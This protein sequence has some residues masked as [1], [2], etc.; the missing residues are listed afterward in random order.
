MGRLAAAF[1]RFYSSHCVTFRIGQILLQEF[2]LFFA[3]FAF[4]SRL[5]LCLVFASLPSFQC[6]VGGTGFIPHVHLV[7]LCRTF[8]V[9]FLSAALVYVAIVLIVPIVLT[10]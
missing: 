1:L 4:V 9:V 5:A 10:K 2:L 6:L 8:I 7:L 3:V